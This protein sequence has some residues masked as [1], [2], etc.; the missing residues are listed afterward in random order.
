MTRTEALA[1]LDEHVKNPNLKK[2]MLAVEAVMRSYA[3]KLNGDP[4]AWGIA[5]L[6]HDF[7]WEIHPTATKHPIKGQPI[8]ESR[9]VPENIRH[10]I[11]AHA[12]HTGV[13][14]ETNMEKVLF[15]SDELAGLIVAVALVSPNRT[16]SDVTIDRVIKKMA[17]KAF[18]ANVNR[19]EIIEGAKLLN[20]PLELHI[21]NVLVAMQ[22]IHETL[23]L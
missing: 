6:L 11:L 18:A 21:G 23:S 13:K 19:D 14:P 8:L 9:G 4:D 10:A 1:I 7:D 17:Q 22:Q 5:G 15:A 16:L 3:D 12:A 2:H 20:I